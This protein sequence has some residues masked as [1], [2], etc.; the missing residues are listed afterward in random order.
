MPAKYTHF[1]LNFIAF[2]FHPII[3]RLAATLLLFYCACIVF[4]FSVGAKAKVGWLRNLAEVYHVVP[5]GKCI[6]GRK[7]RHGA[8][9]SAQ[10]TR[11]GHEAGAT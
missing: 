3:S 6:P 2:G 8:Q 4:Q 1:S 9:P 7:G 10:G 5:T 11:A